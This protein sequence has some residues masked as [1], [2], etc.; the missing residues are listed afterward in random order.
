[1]LRSRLLGGLLVVFALPFGAFA[2]ATESPKSATKPAATWTEGFEGKDALGPNWASEGTT[3]IDKGSAFKDQQSMRLTRTLEN[4]NHPCL[5]LSTEFAVA[6]GT[7]EFSVAAKCDMQSPD[8]SYNGTVEIEYLD[9]NGRVLGSAR[10]TDVHG[11]QNWGFYSKRIELPAGTATA[12]FRAIM[13]K[14]VG[15]FWVDSL[16]ATP[17][18]DAPTKEQQIKMIF[19]SAAVGNLFLPED[20][21]LMQI[22]VQPEKGLTA[23]ATIVYWVIRDY[24]GAEQNEPAVM[25][26]DIAD[27]KRRPSNYKA[28]IDFSK[29]PLQV[30]RYYELH[31][32]LKHANGRVEFHDSTAFAI[33]PEAEANKYKPAEIP[34]TSRSW[35]NRVPET[36][37]LT[38]RL[39]IRIC[40]VASN[41]GNTP[42]YTPGAPNIDVA[43]K[44][45]MQ[46]LCRTPGFAFER[47]LKGYEKLDEEALR[48]SIK[49]FVDKYG[50]GRYYFLGNEPHGTGQIVDDNIAA[51]KVMYE[52]LKKQDPTC[53]VIGTSNGAEEEYFQKGFQMYLDA[54]DYHTYADYTNTRATF[55]KYRE[56]F[57]KYGGGEKPIWTT[58]SGLNSQGMTRLAISSDMVRKIA[59]FFAEGGGSF[60]WF[61]TAYP[62][63]T[64]KLHLNSEDSMNVFDGTWRKFSPRL[65]A[66]TYYNLVNAVTIKK[67]ADEKHYGNI[68]AFLMR[69][70]D[71]NCLL[72]M[73]KE[74]GRQ[75]VG[76]P[77]A[78]NGKAKLTLLDGTSLELAANP[79]I[80][81]N[82]DAILLQFKSDI[83]TLPEKLGQPAFEIL[84]LP[85]SIV[86]G[87]DATIQVTKH[88]RGDNI[89]VTAPPFWEMP[90]MA[91]AQS[92]GGA[93]TELTFKAPAQTNAREAQLIFTD[94]SDAYAI[95]ARIPVAG[96]IAMRLL[97]SP[98]G[99][100]G[101]AGVK[102]IATNNGPEAQDVAW[103][104]SLDEARP[105]VD[106]QVVTIGPVDAY[107]TQTA[108]G[109]IT[110][111]GHSS[112]EIAVPMGNVDPI[113]VYTVTGSLT[114][115]TGRKI[116]ITRPVAGFASVAHNDGEIKPNGVL[117]E[118]AWSKAT[119]VLIDQARMYNNFKKPYSKWNGP[120][121]LSAV[122]KF[123]WDEKALYVGIAVKDDNFNNPKH[124][125]EL[126][127]QDAIQFLIDPARETDA[128]PGKYDYT[129]G[130][131][132]KGPQGWCSL[133]AD[134][135]AL[136]GDVKDVPMMIKRDEA[137]KTTAY[138]LVIPWSRVAP[139]KPVA[140]NNLGMAIG[141]AEDEGK[142]R[143]ALMSWFGNV[144]SKQI[145]GVG[146]LILAP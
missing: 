6:P 84:K 91:V 11:K 5:A 41:F 64:G 16:S 124:D 35:D 51:Y 12:R 104:V 100:G 36:F 136:N 125:G 38:N 39:G 85:A 143:Q 128:K 102:I 98:A 81:V 24:F 1:M 71:D 59:V 55:K 76:L 80:T 130:L 30:G 78:W 31:A 29:V 109:T 101:A 107:F 7:W 79:T 22:E 94:N 44:L 92:G 60:S 48:A 112:Q 34:F 127:N 49:A 142:A 40:G 126:W 10:I 32:E 33:L 25:S 123:L 68:N 8:V 15:Q 113:T 103:S 14:A 133:T 63:T 3:S 43:D 57:K 9:A 23:D 97:A 70:K 129:F 46:A 56:L 111:A 93:T 132:Q 62:D 87:G 50:K 108:Q 47:K 110:L 18:A 13:N 117:D 120:D 69:D 52:E 145:D 66:V 83:T 42:P 99:P 134:A 115:P 27:G 53:F 106:G 28:T 45:N 131:G 135:G 73:W 122:A 75:D 82:E 137:T 21:R 86:K 67:F 138:E 2:Q 61:G 77:I 19:S 140:G 20:K 114:D 141:L 4:V 146:D 74:K 89:S 17:V 116:S 88:G 119:P 95:T 118:A 96:K 58:E 121:D 105:E 37:P 26:M 65:D 144:H 54:Y 139:F 90:A 72:T